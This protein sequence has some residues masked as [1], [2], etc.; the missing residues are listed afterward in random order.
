M[1]NKIQRNPGNSSPFFLRTKILGK[2]NEELLPHH[3]IVLETEWEIGTHYRL[4][5][6][7][8]ESNGGHY[9][10]LFGS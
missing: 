5:F 2:E 8:Q 4:D 7:Q 3:T 1:L 9:D 6:P 10:M